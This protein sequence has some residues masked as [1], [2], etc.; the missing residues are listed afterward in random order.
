MASR[1]TLTLRREDG[2]VVC[3]SVTVADTT[4]RRLRGLLGKGSLRSGEGI[5][6]RPAWSIH[7]AFMRFPIDVVFL[8]HDQVVVRVEES[9]RPFKTASCRGAR[10]IVELPSGECA[11]RGLKVG[12]R[13]AWAPRAVSDDSPGGESLQQSSSRGA[14]VVA[15]SDQRFTKL[16]RFLLDGRGIGVADVVD[17]DRLADAVD[18][19]HPDVV[20]LDAGNE[21][22]R[23]LR[24]AHSVRARHPETTIVLGGD[25]AAAK[26][27]QSARVYDKWQETDDLLGAVAQA[28]DAQERLSPRS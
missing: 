7:T 17:L 1:G 23:A 25:G 19:E 4:L 16:V 8:D 26:A 18:E 20:L 21:L 13:V 12:D 10:E 5:S 3:E 11:R 9:L 14:V 28:L 24:L 2:R 15:S 6:L 22:G 27:P